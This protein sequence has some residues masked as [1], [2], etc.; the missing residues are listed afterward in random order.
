MQDRGRRQGLRARFCVAD[1]G[2][3]AVLS[4]AHFVPERTEPG[5]APA[6]DW[7]FDGDPS[8]VGVGVGAWPRCL[9]DEVCFVSADG[10]GRVVEP[11][12][13]SVFPTC[14]K[15]LVESPVQPDEA[16]AT[17]SSGI[18]Y[19]SMPVWRWPRSAAGW[20]LTARQRLGASRNR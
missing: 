12:T 5:E 13:W 19:R 9:D 11:E 17:C 18:Q 1:V 20:V 6:E 2:D 10:E 15:R 4:A 7:A 16:V 3:D 8:G 14:N